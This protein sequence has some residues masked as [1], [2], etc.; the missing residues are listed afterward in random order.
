MVSLVLDQ[1]GLTAL[2]GTN[3]SPE[4][5]FPNFLF[6]PSIDLDWHTFLLT[7]PGR[8]MHVQECSL[9]SLTSVRNYMPPILIDTSFLLGFRGECVVAGFLLLPLKS[10]LCRPPSPLEVVPC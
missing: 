8:T 4:F 1:T 5:F 6:F 7:V 10:L 2:L 3:L 9:R